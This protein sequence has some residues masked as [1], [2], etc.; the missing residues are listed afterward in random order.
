MIDTIL[1]QLKWNTTLNGTTAVVI[2]EYF[3]NIISATELSASVYSNSDSSNNTSSIPTYNIY[4]FSDKQKTLNLLNISNPSKIL[5]LVTKAIDNGHHIIKK[6]VAASSAHECIV[7]TTIRED[8]IAAT[9]GYSTDSS[10]VHAGNLIEN[11]LPT[12]T[13]V[14]YFPYHSIKLLSNLSEGDSSLELLLLASEKL[15]NVRPVSL[16]QLQSIDGLRTGKR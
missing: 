10:T 2:D 8:A 15:R 13:T 16:V 11:L 12:L 1:K 9:Q 5:F 6:L 4:D 14:F 7:L 3:A